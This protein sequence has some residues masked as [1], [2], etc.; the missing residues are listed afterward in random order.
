MELTKITTLS[1][2]TV[3]VNK[4][5]VVFLCQHEQTLDVGEEPTMLTMV[6]LED[7][8]DFYTAED[9]HSVVGRL[10]KNEIE[11]AVDRLLAHDSN[12]MVVRVRS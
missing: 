6:S 4:D 5:K 3:Y 1:G 7:D 12:G 2:E 8:I 11:E 9:I 10:N